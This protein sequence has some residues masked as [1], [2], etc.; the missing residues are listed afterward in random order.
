MES[1]ITQLLIA[2]LLL[3]IIVAILGT[4]IVV[5]NTT[6]LTGAVSHANFG[7][8]GLSFYLGLSKGVIPFVIGGFSGVVGAILALILLYFPHRRESLITGIWAVGMATGILFIS[9]GRVQNGEVLSYLFGNLLFITTSQLK[10]LG[11]VAGILLLLLPLSKIVLHLHYDPSFLQLRKV[12]VGLLYT[13]YLS[14][15]SVIIGLLVQIVGIILL[16]AL[17]ALPPLIGEQFVTRFYP[18]VGV[19]FGITFTATG[20]AIWLSYLYP[21][22]LLPVVTILLAV[23]LMFTIGIKWVVQEVK[24]VVLVKSEL[25]K[26]Q[27]DG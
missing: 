27:I 15:V 7:A 8:V 1:L 26:G 14:A 4:L 19:T 3:S 16:L 5:T 11:V 25:K 13:F 22:P 24:R 23:M 9:L 12:K 18:L 17:F 10:L 6:T 2:A 21:L 20:L